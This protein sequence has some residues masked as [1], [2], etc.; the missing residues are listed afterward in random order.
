M[1]DAID[2]IIESQRKPSRLLMFPPGGPL[3]SHGGVPQE[4]Y[5]CDG[6]HYVLNYSGDFA[7][8]YDWV[9]DST[10]GGKT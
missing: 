5:D 7:C 4:R 6:G 10:S 3:E 1:Y 2:S 9:P 8:G